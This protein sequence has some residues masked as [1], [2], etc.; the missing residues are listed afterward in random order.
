MHRRLRPPGSAP[1]SRRRLVLSV[2]I[3]IF[4]LSLAVV[5]GRLAASTVGTPFLGLFLD[6]YGVF[7]EVQFPSWPSVPI[8]FPARLQ[9]L[10]G[11]SIYVSLNRPNAIVSSEICRRLASLRQAGTRQ[12][13]LEF[14]FEGRIRTMEREIQFRTFDEVLFFYVVYALVGWAIASSGIAVY[15]LARRR[16]PA[17]AYAFWSVGAGVFFC[18]FYDYHSSALLVPLFTIGSVWTLLGFLW[19]AWAFPTP[20]MRL[21]RLVR[22]GLSTLTASAIVAACVLVVA[23]WIPVDTMALR[24]GLGTLI[25]VS[26]LTLTASLVI[27]LLFATPDERQ[28]LRTATSGL[29]WGSGLIGAGYLLARVGASPLV[30]MCLPI[31]APAIPLAIGYTIIKHDV[32]ST[33]IV[34]ARRLVLPVLT[35]AA[36]VVGLVSWLIARLPQVASMDWFLP[37][38]LAGLA[39][40][41]MFILGYRFLTRQLFPAAKEYRPTIEQLSSRLAILRDEADIVNELR[42]LIL[43]WLPCDR[44]EV[45]TQSE[46]KSAAQVATSNAPQS[47]RSAPLSTHQNQGGLSVPMRFQGSLCGMFQIGPKTGNALFTT[48]D[49]ALLETMAAL[50][51]L[52]LHHTAVLSEVDSLRREQLRASNDER[53]RVVDTLSAEIAHELGHPLRYFRSLFEERSPAAQ[54]SG[55]EVKFALLQIDRMNRMLQTLEMM[56]IPP[57]RACRIRLKDPIDH[58]MLLL[59]EMLDGF[60]TKASICV[61]EE[62]TVQSEHDPLVQVFANLLRNAAQAAGAGGSIGVRVDSV[63]ERLVVDVWDTGPGVAD[64]IRNDLFRVWGTTTRREGRGFG[65][66]ITVRILGQFHWHLEYLREANLTVFRITIPE[67]SD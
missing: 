37:L 12:V 23:P 4:G 25:P 5:G 3:A 48:E 14:Q 36:L 42:R 59:R 33:E 58:A 54:L 62:V 47:E 66:M 30:H 63:D 19:L 64:G 6:P 24:V 35:F 51:A 7:S 67:R 2:A 31:L 39:A 57:P 50:G 8:A 45:L 44:V 17:R 22:C 65:L 27:R 13:T 38:A 11:Q 34:L 15:L 16:A 9:R 49:I 41:L 56:E 46:L 20:P 40:V 43:N 53:S 21:Q 52:A 26:L 28:P 55:E 29:A 1:T 18:T 10:Q 61:P 60:G 32:L